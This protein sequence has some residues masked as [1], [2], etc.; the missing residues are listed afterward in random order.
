MRYHG[1]TGSVS[2]GSPAAPVLSLNKW[3]LN[4][5]TD[6][7]DVTAFGDVN[8][9][10]VQG[11]PDLKGSVGG[12]FDDQEDGLF[13]AADS[14]TPVQLELMPVAGVASIKWAGP[15][16][17]DASIDVPANGAIS[18]SG[19]FVAAGGWTRTFTPPVLDALGAKRADADRAAADQPAERKLA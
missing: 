16:W 4:A 2:I 6:K 3:T 14:T 12:W 9:Q 7:V 5:A 11:L 18:V 13:L 10:Y 15:A 1:K 17:L 19:E 8:K